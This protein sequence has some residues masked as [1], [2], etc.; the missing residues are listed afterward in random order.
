MRQVASSPTTARSAVDGRAIRVRRVK[1][2]TLL[3]YVI[4]AAGTVLVWQIGA[5]F[6]KPTF[7][8]APTNV[9]DSA[10][11][12]I[13]NGTLADSVLAS[14]RRI[15]IGWLIGCLIGAPMGLLMGRIRLLRLI[16]DPYLQLMR[17]LAPI[18]LLSLAILWLGI[19]EESRIFLIVYA[20][21]F[22]VALN[23]MDG[24]MRVEV[25]KTRAA[26]CLGASSRQILWHVVV[27]A[28]MPHIISGVRLAMGNSFMAIVSA[29]MLAAE[30]GLGF[31]IFNARLF[32]LTSHIFV[33]LIALGLCG[34]ATDQLLR[35]IVQRALYRYQVRT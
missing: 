25:E 5:G 16:V 8:P 12:L 15:L 18:A 13:Q 24:A 20:T 19:R 17:F 7:F 22:V 11:R 6:S 33:G 35:L 32:M 27:P 14:Y 30:S 28:T 31:L 29:E 26:Q 4:L 34:M 21:T 23:A 2:R 3:F 10:V 1:V 9:L